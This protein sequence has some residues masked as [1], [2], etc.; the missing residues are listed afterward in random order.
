VR[1]R[2]SL[3][4]LAILAVAAGLPSAD[5]ASHPPLPQQEGKTGIVYTENL[6][7]SL[8]APEG[9]V[10]DNHSAVQQG[11]PAVLYPRGSSWKDAAAVMYPTSARK[12]A[13]EHPVRD[14]IEETLAQ[15]RAASPE[16]RVEALDPFSTG[17]A[18]TAEVRKLSGESQGNVEAIAF[19]E[20]ADRVVLLVLSTRSE[21]DFAAALPAFRQLVRSYS[22][23]S[24]KVLLPHPVRR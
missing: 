22:Y 17:D 3:S 21:A 8:S 12:R 15:H 14:V 13:S 19:I 9:W 2:P 23:L 4:A 5:A 16:L 10:L 1:R 24:D 6:V 18:R 7:F 11:L 20:E